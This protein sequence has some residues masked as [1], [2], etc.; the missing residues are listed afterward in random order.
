MPSRWL[1]VLI[2]ALFVSALAVVDVRTHYILLFAHE[3]RLMS[4]QDVLRVEWGRLL[5]ER[6]TLAEHQRIDRI[7]HHQLHMVMPDP[8]RI[9]LL[10]TQPTPI[11]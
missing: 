8:R 6:G 2:A 4:R 5:L 10:Y 11:P 7:A 1:V 3:Q 9:Q